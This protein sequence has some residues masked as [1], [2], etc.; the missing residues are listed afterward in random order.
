MQNKTLVIKFGGNAL[1][2][3]TAVSFAKSIK[4]LKNLGA[5]VIIVHGGGPQI[6]A[7][8]DALNIQSH[9]VDGMRYTDDK[10][11]SVVEMVLAGQVNKMLAK[12]LNFVG[13]D[14]V[15]LSGTDNGLL[16]AEKLTQQ[17]GKAID[18]GFVGQIT[19]INHLLLQN[20]LN[21][22]LTPVIAPIATS[23]RQETLNI[24]ADI[25][26]GEIAKAVAA[27]AFIL[28]TNIAGL[29]D[30]QG[31]VIY[32]VTRTDI[33]NLINDG[34]INGG[35][36]PKTRS[37]VDVLERVGVVKIIDGRDDNN[38]VATFQQDNIGT[39]ITH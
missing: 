24:N 4:T 28:M 2:E 37:A 15:G 18:L 1:S 32:Q 8:L 30:K 11:L 7:L 9:F 35:M 25:A 17:N 31:Q 27:D 33:D 22:G 13:I 23:Q 16:I 34:T 29:L 21:L 3:A 39:T 5:R 26:A 6:N 20:L 10:T 14:A 12:Q 38:L 19:S 36:I